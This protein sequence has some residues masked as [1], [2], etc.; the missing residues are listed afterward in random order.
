LRI[1]L[2]ALTDFGDAAVLIPVASAMLVWLWFGDARSAAWWWAASVGLCVGLTALLKIFFYGC[3]PVTDVHSPSGHTAFSILVYGSLTLV[4]AMQGK[5]LRRPLAVA[6]GSGLILTIAASRLLLD[7]HSLAEVG[8]GLVIG[9]IS[10]V[11]FSRNLPRRY[12][13]AKVWPLLVTVGVLVTI[14]HGQK[15]HAEEFLHRITGYLHINC[16]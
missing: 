6:V 11:L 1:W 2:A 7:A 16:S 9:T 5:G 14:L 13:Q 10:L 8:L 4:T 12:R 15:L 3:P